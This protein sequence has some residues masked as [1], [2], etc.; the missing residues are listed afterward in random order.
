MSLAGALKV[1]SRVAIYEK[2]PADVTKQD[3]PLYRG[4]IRKLKRKK[5]D[6]D[7]AGKD[8]E[9]GVLLKPTFPAIDNGLFIEV[10]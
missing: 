2:N 6:I 9:C 4:L 1:N 3:E 7:I 8:T 5:E 10:V